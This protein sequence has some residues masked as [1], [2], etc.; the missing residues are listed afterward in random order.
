MLTGECEC[1]EYTVV[2]LNLSSAGGPWAPT[3]TGRRET[4]KDP[5]EDCCG[6]K[7]QVETAQLSI[8][9]VLCLVKPLRNAV[10]SHFAE[11]ECRHTKGLS[12]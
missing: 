4:F 1:K 11:N 9:G 10:V 6:C 3:T 2:N 5:R 8:S 7:A 12:N